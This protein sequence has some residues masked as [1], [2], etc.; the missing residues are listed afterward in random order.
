MADIAPKL[1][2]E[3]MRL[4]QCNVSEDAPQW[5]CCACHHEWGVTHFAPL[6]R[7]L[8]LKQS[9]SADDAKG[10]HDPKA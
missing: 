9:A 2:T 10:R 1:A 5:H 6:L 8:R 7:S 3:E 4:A